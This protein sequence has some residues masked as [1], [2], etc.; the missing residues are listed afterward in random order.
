MTNDYGIALID[1]HLFTSNHEYFT[2]HSKRDNHPATGSTVVCLTF[3]LFLSSLFSLKASCF[4]SCFT[5][6]GLVLLEC[7]DGLAFSMACFMLSFREPDEILL[8]AKVERS[9]PLTPRR[10]A[11]KSRPKE[12]AST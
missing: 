7:L 11:G 10:E 6:S 1:K 9:V 3:T 4:T 2:S 8:F 5:S 12:K